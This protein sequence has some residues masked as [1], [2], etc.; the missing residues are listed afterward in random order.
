MTFSSLIIM[1]SQK[2]KKLGHH[3]RGGAHCGGLVALAAQQTT[4][5]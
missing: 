1:G 4:F 5:G 2:Q 3:P